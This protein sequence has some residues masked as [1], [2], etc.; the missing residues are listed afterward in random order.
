MSADKRTAVM[1]G[2]L[3][4][5]DEEVTLKALDSWFKGLDSNADGK[6]AQ[7]E[8]TCVSDTWARLAVRRLDRDNDRALSKSEFVEAYGVA[9]ADKSG[10]LSVKELAAPTMRR[11]GGRGGGGGRARGNPPAVGEVAPDFTL[12]SL[13]GKTTHTLSSYKG[14]KPVALIFGSYT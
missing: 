3:L 12:K 2:R 6:L 14:K 11:R 13:D 5:A 8:L 7:A 4:G 1:L 9:D 10:T